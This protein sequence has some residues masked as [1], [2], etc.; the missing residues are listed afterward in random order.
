MAKQAVPQ[1]TWARVLAPNC[2]VTEARPWSQGPMPCD[3]RLSPGAFSAEVKA[4]SHAGHSWEKGFSKGGLRPASILG[5]QRAERPG[6]KGLFSDLGSQ[7]PGRGDSPDPSCPSW[8]PSPAHECCS[9]P[10]HTPQSS[11]KPAP[12]LPQAKLA[13]GLPRL[14]GHPPIPLSPLLLSP[15]VQS[16]TPKARAPSWPCILQR[17]HDQRNITA[18]PRQCSLPFRGSPVPPHKSKW[19]PCTIWP[20]PAPAKGGGN[21]GNCH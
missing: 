6:P 4:R 12:P 15:P 3:L 13:R 20:G 5:S 11:S 9:L 19:S 18:V 16:L 14:S 1:E 10:G 8:L 2:H 7:S 21:K 17:L